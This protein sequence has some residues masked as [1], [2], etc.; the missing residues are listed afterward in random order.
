MNTILKYQGKIAATED[1]LFIRELIEK[2][3]ND[4]RRKLS[5]KV[6]EAWNW[7]QSN[8][9]LKDMVC[10]GF[11]LKLHRAGL[12]KLPEKKTNPPNPLIN[13]TKPVL[14]PITKTPINK[15]VSQIK[16]LVIK[17]V[18]KTSAENLY[19]SLIAHYHYLGY[20]HPVGEHVKYI[21]YYQE[22]PI[23]CIAF[24]SAVRHLGDRDRF[25]GW[26]KELRKKNLHL[27]AYNTRFLILP[28]IHIRFL[29]S[30]ILSIIAK[31]ISKDWESIYHHP[32]YLLETFIDTE[33]FD[34]TCY[35]AANWSYI[36]KTT[37]RG[38][39]DQTNRQNRSIKSIWFYPLHKKFKKILN[40]E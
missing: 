4:S 21:I 19:N 20:C 37:G 7:K 32:I 35:K 38:K 23:S 28:W 14:L 18:R 11:M 30:H 1:I 8:G 40:N 34:G 10:R 2:N 16:P 39:N 15:K 22:Q 24:S 25:I 6:C 33:K 17:Q 12:I 5:Q 9:M 13:R 26:N 29:A 3:P 36:G 27:I 31:R